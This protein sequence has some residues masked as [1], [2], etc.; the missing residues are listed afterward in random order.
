MIEYSSQPLFF[1]YLHPFF[2]V[3]SE[4]LLPFYSEIS[5]HVCSGVDQ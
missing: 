5:A 1:L 3:F 2:I 4:Y